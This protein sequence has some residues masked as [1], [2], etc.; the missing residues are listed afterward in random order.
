MS[1]DREPTPEEMNE[2]F[3]S[4]IQWMKELVQKCVSEGRGDLVSPVAM[5]L[6]R[7]APKFEKGGPLDFKPFDRVE[8]TAPSPVKVGVFSPITMT[9]PGLPR[10]PKSVFWTVMK[11]L[12]LRTRAFATIIGMEAWV[13][14]PKTKEEALAVPDS[15]ED[16]AHRK[17]ALVVTAERENEYRLY[18]ALMV[19]D[20]DK[21]TFEPWSET[22]TDRTTNKVSRYERLNLEDPVNDDPPKPMLTG[23]VYRSVGANLKE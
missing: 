22:I 8:D 5:L 11:L 17:E 16:Y 19:R 9:P 14:M 21:L 13:A 12:S 4:Q 23:D 18:Q 6:M 15:L 7:E 2:A 10:M 3:E 1:E 20:G